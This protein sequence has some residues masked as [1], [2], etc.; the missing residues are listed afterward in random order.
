MERLNRFIRLLGLV[1][2]TFLAYSSFG[3][4]EKFLINKGNEA[5]NSGDYIQAQE[6]YTKALELDPN[7]SV[8]EYNSADVLY[9]EQKFEEAIEKY[10]CLIQF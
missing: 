4:E 5:Y 1:C 8:A 7:I 6:N 10:S 9:K 2:F 3:Q